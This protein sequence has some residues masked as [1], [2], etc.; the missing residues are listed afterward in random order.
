MT[1][2]TEARPAT[3]R[4]RKTKAQPTAPPITLVMHRA[5]QAVDALMLSAFTDLQVTPRQYA[6]LLA[7]NSQDNQS[8]NSLVARTGIDRSTLAELV[9]RMIKRGWLI[10][11]RSKTD[12]RQWHVRMTAAGAEVFTK[13]H[14]R[15]GQV[16]RDIAKL[17]GGQVYAVNLQLAL[18]E[19]IT[20]EV[21]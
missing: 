4:G 2:A 9:R 21:V 17:V 18:E 13:A 12:L 8:Q 14:D 15:A 10:R 19:I 6:L 7:V 1:I 5:G 3:T 16:D 20:G 11:S